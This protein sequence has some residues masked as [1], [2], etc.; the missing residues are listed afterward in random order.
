MMNLVFSWAG[1]S[2]GLFSWRWMSSFFTLLATLLLSPIA[3]A[4]RP[5]Q[6][7]WSLAL[8]HAI[9]SSPAV[10]ADG[11]IYIGSDN[12]ELT[13]IR[14]DGTKAWSFPC[15]GTL[16]ASPAIGPSGTIFV[17]STGRIVYALNPDGSLLW[18]DSPGGP[19]AASPAITQDGNV[20]VATV[21]GQLLLLD[22]LGARKWI[23]EA[24]ANIV[25]SPVVAQDGMI[26]FG[27]QNG[28][29]HA[30][31]PE[32]NRAWTLN[33]GGKINASPAL[34][35]NGVI[36]VGSSTGEFHALTPTGGKA[37]SVTVEDGIRGSAVVSEQGHIYFGSDDRHLHALDE[38]G[39]P[40]WSFATGYWVRGTPV[41]GADHS[42]YFGS[43]DN[44]VYALDALGNL[45]WSQNTSGYVSSS[46]ALNDQGMLLIGSWDGSFM[47]IQANAPLAT[48][49]WPKFRGNLQNQ[50]KQNDSEESATTSL[51]PQISFRFIEDNAVELQALLPEPLK[52]P[53]EVSFLEED[54]V[55][56]I[57]KNPPYTWI[58]KNL[59]FKTYRPRVRIVTAGGRTLE[60]KPMNL[61]VQMAPM[62]DKKNPEIVLDRNNLPPTS[63]SMD[64]IVKGRAFDDQGIAKVEYKA[65]EQ[66]F[67]TAEGTY[68]W[69]ARIRLEP[70]NNSIR[71]RALDLSGNTSRE[72]Q[73]TVQFVRTARLQVQVKGQGRLE[74]EP[75]A[76]PEEL[77][78][79]TEYTL[80][81]IPDRGYQFSRWEGDWS[82]NEASRT[83]VMK[84]GLSVTA[85]FEAMPQH[86]PVARYQ[87]LL[88]DS[89][90]P[91]PQVAG[92]I[93][94]TTFADGELEGS[95]DSFGDILPFKAT[96][97]PEGS[98]TI[99]LHRKQLPSIRIE[100]NRPQDVAFS[101]EGSGTSAGWTAPIMLDPITEASP[102]NSWSG[103]FGA[104]LSTSAPAGTVR[105]DGFLTVSVN[106]ENKA[107]LKG[108]LPDGTAFREKGLIPDSGIAP[109]YIVLN[110]SEDVLLGW[111]KHRPAPEGSGKQILG[112]L[113]RIQRP[114]EGNTLTS[115]YT[116]LGSN[117]SEQALEGLFPQQVASVRIQSSET[118]D[119]IFS[120]LTFRPSLR[121]WNASS[122][123]RSL[124][125]RINPRDGSFTGR[126]Q[127]PGTRE[128]IPFD[129]LVV[130]SRGFGSGFLYGQNP[131]GLVII[132]P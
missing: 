104:I 13:A 12:G 53:R 129:G 108:R 101:L 93:E 59:D 19:V 119:L 86:T 47:A 75:N 15:A 68:E 69:T 88:L 33:L 27:D 74:L 63:A 72:I 113:C 100:L 105:G 60:S 94:L 35:A 20:I 34:G 52:A 118:G 98:T 37:W 43:Y 28:V 54:R 87:G 14:P 130:P 71:I 5:G 56:T 25:S 10:A 50:G 6:V 111:I 90:A 1:L 31:T 127:L 114:S 124:S 131:A 85:H 107:E 79:G 55:L 57:L 106:Q 21:F 125:L 110:R 102:A 81:A 67:A 76:N 32:G 112:R 116:A 78:M 46:G 103:D 97:S 92:Y 3:E 61:T 123:D 26:Y 40:L 80:K 49:A 29:F 45:L 11:T 73:R 23:Y 66:P 36:Y 99:T 89:A 70:G 51:L 30:V 84:E 95:L 7:I 122:E 16:A 126:L 44:K 121:S 62:E 82:G 42:I 4:A 48:G 91:N 109:W 41:L 22:A 65:N 39:K 38:S 132:A 58:W 128:T 2:A 9:Q 18:L 24:E 8:G 77:D 115:L 96:W 17:A 117:Y 83:F 120:G 64:L